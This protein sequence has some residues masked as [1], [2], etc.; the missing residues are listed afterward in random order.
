M[1]P[2]WEPGVRDIDRLEAVGRVR[3]GLASHDAFD[4]LIELAVELTGVRRACITLVDADRTV[5]KS[6]LGFPEGA[7]L[8]APVDQS[9]CRFVVASAAP[10][11][12]DDARDDPRTRGDAAI[13]AFDAVTWA[14]YP[15]EDGAGHVVGTFCLMD[16]RPHAWTGRDLHVLATLAQAASSEIALGIANAAVIE[17]WRTLETERTQTRAYTRALLARLGAVAS[18]GEADAASP[19]IVGNWITGDSAQVA[20]TTAT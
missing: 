5:A 15:V 17:A 18:P 8:A 6:A 14:G 10:L 20:S 13:E 9:F 1:V 16:C 2:D 4:R 3:F 11:V 7:V 12:V 19:R